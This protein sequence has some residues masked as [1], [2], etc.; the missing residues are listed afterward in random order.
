[1]RG[2]HILGNGQAWLKIDWVDWMLS[3]PPKKKHLRIIEI[4]IHSL[5]T[6]DFDKKNK[7]FFSGISQVTLHPPVETTR[8]MVYGHG[9]AVNAHAWLDPL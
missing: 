3:N 6:F 8:T 7:G 2:C 5:E 4:D 9:V 1:M